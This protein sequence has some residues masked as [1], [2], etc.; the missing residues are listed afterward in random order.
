MRVAWILKLKMTKN[1]CKIEVNEATS[2]RL[3][4]L[5][6]R[7]D[8]KCIECTI[9]RN[10]RRT[11]KQNDKKTIRVNSAG[12]IWNF[13]SFLISW[14]VE[15]IYHFRSNNPRHR[16]S[17][18]KRQ[19]PT[20]FDEWWQNKTVEQKE[21]EDEK[22]SNKVD[23]CYRNLPYVVVCWSM[24]NVLLLA[25]CCAV[26]AALCSAHSAEVVVY[27]HSN[28]FVPLDIGSMFC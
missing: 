25:Q 26:F 15:T 1:L 21:D 2:N 7:L 3:N 4:K 19:Q 23:N 22:R 6:G 18:I 24:T 5:N 9:N 27:R 16:I 28:L 17:Y 14:N 12:I 20:C 8:E 11:K 13:R 10:I